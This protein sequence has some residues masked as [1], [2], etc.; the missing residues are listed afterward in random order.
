METPDTPNATGREPHPTGSEQARPGY[1]TP[2]C[3]V[4]LLP[5][6]GGGVITT[7]PQGE[8][9]LACL[10]HVGRRKWKTVAGLALFFLIAAGFY[11]FTAQKVALERAGEA[12][13]ISYM[14]MN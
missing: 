4:S 14:G 7:V 12:A 8:I 6:E 11:L 10:R 5:P 13:D 2:G 3:D 9:N 1:P